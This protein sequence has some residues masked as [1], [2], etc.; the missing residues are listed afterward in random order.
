MAYCTLADIKGRISEEVLIQLT[1]D[2]EVGLVDAAI[3]NAAI[4]D[5]DS[6]IDGY[7]GTRYAV[8]LSP[9]PPRIRKCSAVIAVY[10]LF[11]R[12]TAAPEEVTARYK[13]EVAFLRDVSKGLVSLGQDEPVAGASPDEPGISSQARVFSRDKLKGF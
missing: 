11:G 6:E 10:N 8:P 13:N 4:L 5:A 9:V 2:H 12:R 3:V 1:D 7:C